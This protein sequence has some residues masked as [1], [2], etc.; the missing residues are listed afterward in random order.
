[1]LHLQKSLSIDYLPL[2]TTYPSLQIQLYLFTTEIFLQLQKLVM[3]FNVFTCAI[4]LSST[5]ILSA[6][7]AVQ[8]VKNFRSDVALRPLPLA[9]TYL[10]TRQHKESTTKN[11]PSS[12]A[13]QAANLDGYLIIQGFA[14]K[15]CTDTISFLSQELNYCVDASYETGINR[16][17]II[18]A[19]ATNANTTEYKDAACTVPWGTS[20]STSVIDTKILST[21]ECLIDAE[22]NMGSKFYYSISGDLATTRALIRQT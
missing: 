5:Q 4:L 19:T 20:V 11:L 13:L 7:A 9:N 1:M 12:A 21:E 8:P 10:A 17:R 16:Y 15:M 3:F 2:K 14:D 22:D 6:S 18:T